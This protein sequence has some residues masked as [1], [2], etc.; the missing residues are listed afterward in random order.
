MKRLLFVTLSAMLFLS[1]FFAGSVSTAS[2]RETKILEF[3]TMVGLPQAFTGTQNP[4]RG[5]NGGGLPWTLS[6]ASGELKAS[7]RL[8]IKVRGLVFAAG[9]N[10]GSNTVAS[11]RAIVSCLTADGSVQ[12]VMTDP[13]PATTGPASSGGG[14]AKIETTVSLPQPCIAPIVFVT[15]P[16]GAWFAVTG[17]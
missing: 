16:N 2:A 6:S 8:E 10:T 13:F 3:D 12:N 1:A 15:S 11:F 17:N 7:G 14:N 9:P 4:I 5:I